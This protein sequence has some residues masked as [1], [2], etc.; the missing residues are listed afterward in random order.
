MI[1]FIDLLH[2]NGTPDDRVTDTETHHRIDALQAFLQRLLGRCRPVDE[3]H[4]DRSLTLR[5]RH[6]A[7]HD[8]DNYD[9][10][11]GGNPLSIHE[12]RSSSH[13]GT[14]SEACVSRHG[15]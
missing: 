14:H 13:F 3:T 9:R 7:S 6:C 12:F 1:A 2:L 11:Y 5:R 4:D 8:F 10:D 15:H